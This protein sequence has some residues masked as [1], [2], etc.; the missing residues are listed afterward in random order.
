MDANRTISSCE[1]KVNWPG[2]VFLRQ[3]GFPSDSSPEQTRF[4][5]AFGFDAVRERLANHL[6]RPVIIAMS[7]VRV[8]QSAVNQII[9]VIAVRNGCVAAVGTMNVLLVV[10]FRT[11]RAFVGIHGAD[12]DG[13]FVHMVAVRMMQMAIVKIIHVPIVHDGDVSAI[14]AM[15]MRMIGVRFAGM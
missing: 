5:S 14:F 10:A 4:A 2:S 8:M 11:E 15:D 6:K 13:V 1:L 12:G 9:N 3:T 7:V